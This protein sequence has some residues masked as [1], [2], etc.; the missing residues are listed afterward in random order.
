MRIE[1]R[2]ADVQVPA[3]AG[4]ANQG[5]QDAAG[6]SHPLAVGLERH[7]GE[8]D[9]CPP[10]GDPHLV[11]G[12]LVSAKGDGKVAEQSPDAL[13]EEPRGPVVVGGGC[14]EHG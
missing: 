8:N 10:P 4:G 2:L 5:F 13:L 12:F 9:A 1:E 7:E 3:G 6:T 14:G 11:D